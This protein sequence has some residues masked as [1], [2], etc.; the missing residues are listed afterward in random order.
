MDMPFTTEQFI[1]VFKSYNNAVYP[2]QVLLCLLAAVV[3]T[4]SIKKIALGDKIISAI[5]A[6]FWLWMGIVYHLQYFSQINNAAIAFG[7]VFILQGILFLYLGVI[8]NKLSYSFR[9]ENFGW[10]GVL[11]VTYALIIYPM[12]GYAFGHVYP[13]SPTF[14]LPCP[15]TIFTFGLLI[16]LQGKVPLG[17][18]VIPFLWSLLGFSAALTLGIREDTGLLIA[19][20]SGL[21]VIVLRRR[22]P[23][24]AI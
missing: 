20:I 6:F 11:L 7:A 22:Q 13:A 24:Y 8:G 18:I 14:G 15:T 16:W 9:L 19:G 5:L 1:E 2:M 12:L 17:I 3:I 23:S 4:L 10:L 21:I